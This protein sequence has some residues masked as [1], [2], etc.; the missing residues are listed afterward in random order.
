MRIVYKLY[1]D[2][3]TREA[4]HLIVKTCTCG[5][6]AAVPRIFSLEFISAIR[7]KN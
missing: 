7:I 4:Y 3:A 1:I 6:G 5:T 2:S